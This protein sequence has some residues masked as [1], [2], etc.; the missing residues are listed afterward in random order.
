MWQGDALE[1]SCPCLG[2]RFP[3]EAS[4]LCPSHLSRDGKAAKG[5]KASCTDMV[6]QVDHSWNMDDK[7]GTGQDG[8]HERPS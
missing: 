4:L 2:T 1:G 8:Y 6:G 3:S 5:T 7:W